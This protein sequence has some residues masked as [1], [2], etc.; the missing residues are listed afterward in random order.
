[1]TAK[2][3][4]KQIYYMNRKV[5]RLEARREQLRAQMYSIGSPAGKMDADKV[6]TSM[7][8]DTMLKLIAKVDEAE[9]DMLH[10]ID[11]MVEA[12]ERIAGEIEKLSNDKQRDVLHKRYVEF[13]RWEQ[14][15]VDMN[16]T[17]RHVYRIHG[18]ALQSF[19]KIFKDVIVCHKQKC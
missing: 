19:T 1:M 13:K 18:E 3:Y 16:I 17:L 12:Q 7:N 2:E 6:Q 8:G 5:K 11:R 4:L 10:E 9:R 14:I 15:A